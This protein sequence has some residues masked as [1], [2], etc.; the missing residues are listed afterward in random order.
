LKYDFK[1]IIGPMFLYFNN[2]I[3]TSKINIVSLSG[4]IQ[5][6]KNLTFLSNKI[7]ASFLK[8]RRSL[9][10]YFFAAG[11]GVLVQY[12]VGT[13]FCIRYLGLPFATGVSWGYIA[14]VPVGFILSK[15]FVFDAKKSGKTEREVI[16]FIITLVISYLITVY[17]AELCLL[18]LTKWFGDIRTT[19]PLTNSQFSPIGTFSHFAGMGLSF[20]FNFVAH[21]KFTFA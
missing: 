10:A 4:N 18:Q 20:V 6:S 11:G 14:A 9:F 1:Q 17:G 13:I 2:P 12:I 16:K 5:E 21:K 15:N 19:I 8:N 7:Q 3:S